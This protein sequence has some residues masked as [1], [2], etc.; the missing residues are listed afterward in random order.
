MSTATPPR[1]TGPA[2]DPERARRINDQITEQTLD[3]ETDR[4]RVYRV[5]LV[6]GT[7]LTV[8]HDL[9]EALNPFLSPVG[10]GNT[11]QVVEYA[12]GRA[13]LRQTAGTSCECWVR[14]ERLTF[15]QPRI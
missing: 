6:A 12:F 10:V 7:D 3:R 11:V 2:A 8:R 5:Q 4:Y 13:V 14:F 9:R 15:P 1:L